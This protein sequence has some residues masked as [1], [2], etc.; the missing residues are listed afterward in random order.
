MHTRGD[1]NE[2]VEDTNTKTILLWF[3]ETSHHTVHPQTTRSMSR[4]MRTTCAQAPLLHESRAETNGPQLDISMHTSFWPLTLTRLDRWGLITRACGLRGAFVDNGSCFIESYSV[5]YY[6][7]IAIHVS[8]H[9]VSTYPRLSCLA[10]QLPTSNA[11][12]SISYLLWT[13]ATMRRQRL[14]QS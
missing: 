7:R 11:R 12:R 10:G 8:N 1:E 13:F 2:A 5:K 9:P 4:L 6:A 3:Q 14:A